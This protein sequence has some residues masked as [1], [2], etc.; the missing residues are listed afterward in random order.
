MAVSGAKPRYAIKKGHMLRF[1][2]LCLLFGLVLASVAVGVPQWG[3]AQDQFFTQSGGRGLQNAKTNARLTKTE[4]DVV[5]IQEDL[6]TIQPHARA[7]LGNCAN[8]GEKLRYDGRN[9]ICE[10]ETDPTVKGFAKKDLPSCSGSSILGVSGG[11]LGC[12]ASSFVSDETD[13]TVQQYAKAPLPSCGSEQLLSVVNGALV[14]RTDQQGIAGEIDPKVHDFARKDVVAAIPNCGSN[15]VLTMT[16]ARLSC[17]VESVGIT[18]E[19]DPLIQDFARTDNGQAPLAAC[20]T[21]EVI[22]ASV[23][24]G[25]VVL[26]CVN[27][28][29]TVT[30]SLALDDIT[31][32]NAPAPTSGTVLTFSGGQWRALAAVG[33]S[34]NPLLLSQLGDV[35]ISGPGTDQLLRWNGSAWVNSNDKVGALTDTNWCRVSG[36]QVVCDRPM[37]LTCTTGEALKWNGGTSTWFC[38]AMSGGVSTTIN[39]NA[40]T[41]VTITTPVVGHTIRFDGAGWANSTI[42]RIMTGDTQIVATDTGS[43]GLLSFAT[44]GATRMAINNQGRVGIGVMPSSPFALDVSGSIRTSTHI[45]ATG[46][47]S[48]NQFIGQFVGDGSG[49]T[50]ISV[51]GINAAGVVGS[52]QYK[53]AANEISGSANYTVINAVNR[54][55]V[56]ISGTLK[57]AGSGA[58]S[59]S[60]ASQYGQIRFVDVAGQLTLQI[61][62]P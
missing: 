26:G 19:S 15:Q 6:K 17:K 44:D 13:P 33:T 41:D 56:T 9:W 45:S 54:A 51:G 29:T 40:L 38:E 23:V 46:N 60:G 58:E 2:P 49:I 1:Q 62:R 35:T 36:G 7:Q 59:C 39:L 31:D 24:G 52:V 30:T 12:V 10:K 28:A 55:D 21:G 22:K 50:G 42:E 32:V 57:V 27:I 11:E 61:C 16:G 4:A 3:G 25:K 8:T 18:V 20:A 43:D 37:P 14:C 53:G 48:A 5:V 34:G 47:I